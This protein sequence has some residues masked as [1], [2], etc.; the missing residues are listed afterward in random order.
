MRHTQF[1]MF[2][3]S[4][5]HMKIRKKKLY[6]L[7]NIINNK[8][9]KKL[10]T[11]RFYTGFLTTRPRWSWKIYCYSEWMVTHVLYSVSRQFRS[12]KSRPAR[13]RFYI[14]DQL[15]KFFFQTL[16]IFMSNSDGWFSCGTH[17]RTQIE[18]RGGGSNEPNQIYH[19]YSV[20]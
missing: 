18:P 11:G 1:D 14:S 6:V 7:I 3:I 10:K 20:P 13:F 16:F 8:K 4:I 12:K 2:V 19:F 9:N 5:D 17:H 15:N